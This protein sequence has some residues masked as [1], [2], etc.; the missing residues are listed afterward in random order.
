MQLHNFLQTPFPQP[1]I[2]HN[3]ARIRRNIPLHRQKPLPNLPIRITR[4]RIQHIH[5][6]VHH[7][8][9]HCISFQIGNPRHIRRGNILPAQI[10]SQ[11]ILLEHFFQ[12]FETDAMTR[13]RNE[14]AVRTE[15]ERSVGH[16]VRVRE[17]GHHTW[18]A[19]DVAAA[20]VDGGGEF[21][22]EVRSGG[23]V[24]R[25]DLFEEF[26]WV[27]GRLVVFVVVF[28]FVAIAFC[29]RPNYS[30]YHGVLFIVCI[31]NSSICTLITS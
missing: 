12:F 31:F 5:I 28:H 13:F 2:P 22:V 23:G 4:S 7:R 24:V 11:V 6:R 14:S 10:R 18:E 8:Q 16:E 1:S 3:R 27:G 25:V 17:A 9:L 19:E 26:D 29:F 21:G 20:G 30:G 15:E